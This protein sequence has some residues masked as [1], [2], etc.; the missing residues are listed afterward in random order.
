MHMKDRLGKVLVVTTGLMFAAGAHAQSSVTLYG[1]ADAGLLFLSKTR[2]TSGGDGG[3][4]VSFTDSG[5]VPSLLGLTGKEDLG[6]GLSAEFKLE[7]GIDIANG[8]FNDSN[9]NFF[10]R[11]AY[12]GLTGGFGEIKAG[13]QFSPFF[14][15]LFDL[16]PR[17]LSQFGSSL[18]IYLNNAAATGVFN[19]NAL[20]YTSPRMAG[21]QGSV[22]FALGGAAGNFAAGRQYSASLSYQWSGLTIDAAFYDGNPGGTVQTI[23]PST[24]GFEGRMIGAAYQYGKLTAK[25]SFTNYKMAETGANNNVYGG[26]VDYALTPA[27]DLNGGIWYISNRND[28]SSHSLMSALGAS[29]FLSKATTLYTQVGTVSNRGQASLGLQVGDAP[30]SLSAPYGTTVGAT[31]GIRHVF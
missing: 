5:L 13:L 22:M 10:G 3:R 27:V 9:G 29:Y 20:S 28:R 26:G 24:L 31:I 23:P 17:G 25:V 18:P 14:D 7:S 6:G 2:N 11:Q 21:L 30:A 19:A 4:L 8:G 12:V 1:M 15:T 16:D